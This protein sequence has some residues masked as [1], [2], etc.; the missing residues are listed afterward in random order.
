MARIS[1]E[2][3]GGKNV[4]AG[5][6]MIAWSE[7]TSSARKSKDDG[8]DV[9]V[10]GDTFSGYTEHPRIA[11]VTR[12]GLSD[13]AGRYQIMAAIPNVIRTDTWDWA[14]R[15]AKVK[16]FSPESQDRV[17]IYLIKRRGAL[18]DLKAGRIRDV[19]A[20][21][22]KEWASLPGAGY[23]QREQKVEDLVAQYRAAGGVVA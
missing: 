5:L 1:A 14:S 21:C 23:N 7:G 17:A 19:I 4:L 15:A 9:L 16:D 10:G 20:K 3:A 2:K 18:D 11:V 12:Y 8:Y 13:A 6:D 22:A